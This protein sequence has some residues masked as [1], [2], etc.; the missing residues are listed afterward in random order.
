MAVLLVLLFAG[1]KIFNIE[2]DVDATDGFYRTKKNESGEEVIDIDAPYINKLTHYTIIFNAFVFMQIFNEINARKLGD[3]EYN[4][5]K[6]FLNN[7]LFLVIVISTCCIQYL[8]VTYG[9]ASVRTTPL[10]L[11]QHLICLG[12]GMF[13]LIQGVIVKKALPVRW[14]SWVKIHDEPMSEEQQQRSAIALVRKPTFRKSQ[15]RSMS[16]VGDSN[17]SAPKAAI[18]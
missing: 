4:V 15:M 1:P 12:I 14:F 6:G 9:G 10:T 7:S 3:F 16:K 17:F 2:Y 18:N 13:S 11:E 8:M 5:F